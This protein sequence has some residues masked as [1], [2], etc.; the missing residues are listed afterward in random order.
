MVE[1]QGRDEQHLADRG[2]EGDFIPEIQAQ[3]QGLGI[4]HAAPFSVR[5]GRTLADLFVRV[6]FK[7]V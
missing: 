4:R 6:D 5:G 1:A 7:S 3:R 2:V